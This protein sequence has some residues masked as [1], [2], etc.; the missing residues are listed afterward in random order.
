MD[1]PRF[2]RLQV[3]YQCS[4]SDEEE[5]VIPEKSKSRS[6]ELI[7]GEENWSK[8]SKCAMKVK[9]SDTELFSDVD[10]A[11]T[12]KEESPIVSSETE[13]DYSECSEV[14][15]HR[16]ALFFAINNDLPEPSPPDHLNNNN[17]V[18]KLPSKIISIPLFGMEPIGSGSVTI[19]IEKS[20]RKIP[21]PHDQFLDP[22]IPMCKICKNKPCGAGTIKLSQMIKHK[23]KGIR[24]LQQMKRDY[25]EQE[26]EKQALIL[27]TKAGLA[28]L[29]KL[30]KGINCDD[31][32]KKYQEEE[33]TDMEKEIKEIE[34]ENKMMRKEVLELQIYAAVQ[35]DA[36][37]VTK[38]YSNK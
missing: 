38:H 34:E 4:S 20:K 35:T 19:E 2:R 17:V 15:K 29:E 32:I 21:E 33:I 9:S 16:D 30:D 5:I 24:K 13:V 23:G 1:S 27:K 7:P 18:E 26:A 31:L 36:M 25:A 14:E 37:R 8:I 10:E 11:K 28:I 6:Q 12:K 3:T 22:P